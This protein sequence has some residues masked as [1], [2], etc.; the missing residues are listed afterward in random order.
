[1]DHTTLSR[2]NRCINQA[3]PCMPRVCPCIYAC[4]PSCTIQNTQEMHVDH[5]KR[6]LGPCKMHSVWTTWCAAHLQAM[7]CACTLAWPGLLPSLVCSWTC[8][9]LFVNF[10]VLRLCIL[11]QI[12]MFSQYEKYNNIKTK[13]KAINYI[14]R[15]HEFHTLSNSKGCNSG[16][17]Q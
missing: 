14:L 7:T 17:R 15:Y 6:S 2:V 3:N 1:M 11:D 13:E 5:A 16:S 9:G 4:D 8:L 10:L 12:K